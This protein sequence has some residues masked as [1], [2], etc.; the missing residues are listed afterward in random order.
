MI[1]SFTRLAV[2][3]MLLAFPAA[4]AISQEPV[5]AGMRQ[6]LTLHASFDHGPDADQARGD[7]SLW[8]A[9]A[10]NKREAAVK[11]LPAGGEVVLEPQGGRFGG[12][13]RF[14][15]SAGPMVFYR[16]EKNF[17]RPA[18]G[19][20]GTVSFW[21]SVD[22][23]KDLPDG[24][25]DPLQVTSKQ[26]DDA[27]FF[28]EFEKRPAGI[29]FRLGV[30]A[31]RAVWNPQGRKWEDIP[32]AEKP[33]T[34]VEKPPFAGDKWTHVAFT[35]SKFNSGDPGGAATLYL[36]GRT[37]GQIKPRTQTFTWDASRAAVMLGLGYVGRM[38]DLAL[39]DRALTGD[40]IAALFA[41]SKGV[42][43]LRASGK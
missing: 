23:A 28:V 22:P 32:V 19:W 42:E 31:D 40:E 1:R 18:A 3:A 12:A 25:C 34:A 43:G 33:L 30:Y 11:G 4:V 8:N 21:L 26:W 9:P 41:L 7:R 15:K 2:G 14:N 6:A 39:F 36:D 17:P 10:L 16:A 5:V 27:S 37:A 24:F 35:F 20:G 29:P 38:D 13:M